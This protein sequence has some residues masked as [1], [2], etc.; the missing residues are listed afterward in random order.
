MSE[1]AN[2]TALLAEIE[3][4]KTQLGGLMASKQNSGVGLSELTDLDDKVMNKVKREIESLKHA[5]ESAARK[6]AAQQIAP[7]KEAH[8]DNVVTIERSFANMSAALDELDR[9]LSSRIKT[10]IADTGADLLATKSVAALS[11]K[12][13]AERILQTSFHFANSRSKGV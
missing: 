12:M 10:G 9:D 7:L 13:A 3:A 1:T 11:A 2:Y 8:N 4:I 6:A 5:V